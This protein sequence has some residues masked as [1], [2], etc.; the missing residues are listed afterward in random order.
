MT[1][2]VPI[3]VS[4]VLLLATAIASAQ[5]RSAPD[6]DWQISHVRGGVYRVHAGPQVTVF[7]V[8]GDGIVLVDPLSSRV[9]AWLKQ[10]LANRFPQQPV[11]YVVYTH[12]RFDRAG[13]GGTFDETAE[14]V[15]HEQF[16]K[17]RTRAA[18]TLPATLV[19]LDRN[20]DG[21]L[22]RD[23]VAGTASASLFAVYDRNEDRHVTPG[24]LYSYVRSPE[25]TYR[26][27]R[28]LILNGKSVELISA[29]TSQAADMTAVY[30]PE[31]R[32][33]F[34]A[35]LVSVRSV[36]ASIGPAPRSTIASMQRIEGLAFDTLLTGNGE[37]GTAADVGVFRNYLLELTAGVSA[38]FNAGLSVEETKRLVTLEK[39][40]TLTGFST[41]REHNVAELYAG[42][43]PVLTSVYASTNL[44][45]QRVQLEPCQDVLYD[46]CVLSGTSPTLGGAFGVSVSIDRL[47]L[48]GE[49][50]STQAR[51]TR[52]LATDSFFAP[53]EMVF[54]HRDT[55]ASFLSGYRLGRMDG[56]L[57]VM[58]AGL[59]VISTR[60]RLTR[61]D[62]DS[63][64]GPWSDGT[65]QSTALL[66]PTFGG[67]VMAPLTS[68]YSVVL[69]VRLILSD[70]NGTELDGPLF[71]FGAGLM[72]NVRRSSR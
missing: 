65:F 32:L 21:R 47:T 49:I 51:T 26:A 27:R 45:L 29:P 67:T 25:S 33:L 9:S 40:S 50:S 39:F 8:T 14:H 24:E 13:G 52:M 56:P 7:F 66:A 10:E 16:F 72:V 38:G 58:Q 35:D 53:Y 68:R 42:L 70:R 41:Q 6:P 17:E 48:G 54:Q 30:F 11:R 69:P 22:D 20:G 61:F 63:I 71:T 57:V 44:L 28:T 59:S 46:S 62:T 1:Q 18:E 23:E 31:E 55:I 3:L 60:S 2:R 12:H 4:V 15:A 64:N 19:A 36:P 34:G 37:D 5:E 43:R